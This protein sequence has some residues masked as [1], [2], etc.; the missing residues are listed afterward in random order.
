M[1]EE[2]DVID[3]LLEGLQSS[4]TV[5]RI[6]DLHALQHKILHLGNILARFG[7]KLSENAPAN[8]SF[9]GQADLF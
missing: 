9:R 3:R 7:M 8:L 4:S 6:A 1:E 5:R 2:G